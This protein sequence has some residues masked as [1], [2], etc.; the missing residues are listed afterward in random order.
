MIPT[1]TYRGKR[2]HSDVLTTYQYVVPRNQEL[3]P[4]I[5]TRFRFAV[6]EFKGIGWEECNH[7]I[8]AIRAVAWKEGKLRDLAWTADFASLHFSHKA[9]KWHCRLPQD[10]RENWAKLQVALLDRWSPPDDDDE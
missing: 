6:E 4:G 5:F 10:V 2:S 3:C 7:F 8:R 9:L 1:T